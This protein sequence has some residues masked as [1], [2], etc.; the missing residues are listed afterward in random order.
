MCGI[1]GYIHFN[2]ERIVDPTTIRKMNDIISHRGPDGEGFYTEN[3]VA[4]GHRRL[5]IIDLSTGHQPM[6]SLDNQLVIVFNGEIYNYIELREELV[7]EGFIFKTDSDTEVILNAYLHWGIECQNKF[8]GMW[9]FALYDKRNQEIF[10]SRDRI[11][12]KPL[13]YSVFDNTFIFGSE[14]KSLFQYGIPKKQRHELLEIYLTLT[15]IPAP[16]TFFDGVFKLMPGHFILVKNGTFSEHKYWDLPE[17]DENNMLS[18]KKLIYSKFEELLDDSVKIRMRSDVSFGAFLSGGLDSSS[19]VGLMSKHTNKPI[20]TFTIGF[21]D[22][23]FD[24][25]KLAQDVATKFG[26]KHFLGT[27]NPEQ[28]DEILKRTAFHY[29]E[30]FGD[31]SAIPTGYVSKFAAENVK[32]VLTG[33]GGDEVLSGYKSYQGIKLSNLINQFPS[34]LINFAIGSNTAISRLSKGK[35]RYKLNKINNILQTSQLDFVPRMAQKMAYTDLKQIKKMTSSLTN[36]ISV[37]DFMSDLMSKSTYNDDF[38]KMMYLDFKHELPNDYLVKV[39]RMS[40]AYSL[41]SRVPFLDHRLIEFMVHVDKNVKMQGWERKSVLRNSIGKMLP[42]S[43][44]N[45]P[46]KGFGV[47]LREWFK[48]GAY[49]SFLVNNLKNVT[50]I[51]DAKIINNIVNQNNTG[52]KDN[53]NFIWGMMMLNKIME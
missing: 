48:D 27:V 15:N 43:I 4:L 47:P 1:T 46:K 45:A 25:S 50:E 30:P 44:L 41:E 32:M 11:G 26:T 16:N 3:N 37:E 40:M 13:H 19:I 8:N 49:N 10:I 33:D 28:F 24:E 5:S 14:M 51:M 52:Q 39:D 36:I 22:K 23:A 20:N 29:D 53:G 7:K 34:P 6:Y 17:I 35:I 18:D 9:A 38:Y 21:E 31:S 42:E 2:R 12:E